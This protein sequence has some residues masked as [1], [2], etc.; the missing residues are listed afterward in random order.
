MLLPAKSLTP[1]KTRTYCADN[2]NPAHTDPAHARRLG[3][4]API[5]AGNQLVNLH[6]DALAQTLGCPP[7]ALDV[8]IRFRRP[9]F[10]DDTLTVEHH[11]ATAAYPAEIRLRDPSGRLVS[12]CQVHALG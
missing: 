6:L 5:A 11:P 12:T 8:T 7:Q 10:W 1:A 9:A 2:E 3:F 4:R